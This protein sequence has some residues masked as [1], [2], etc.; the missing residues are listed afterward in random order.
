MS[1]WERFLLSFSSAG[2]HVLILAAG[3][4]LGVWMLTH[5]LPEGKE[6]LAASGGALLALL[7][8]KAE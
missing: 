3:V 8:P 5:G 6:V 2:G 1:Y 7:R 4:G